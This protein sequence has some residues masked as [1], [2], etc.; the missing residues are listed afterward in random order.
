MVYNPNLE[1]V[2]ERMGPNGLVQIAWNMEFCPP[3]TIRIIT[4]R[5]FLKLGSGL[6][7][8]PKGIY[9]VVTAVERAVSE[10]RIDLDLRV[11]FGIVGELFG[12]QGSSTL[13]KQ[14]K[15]GS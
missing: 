12:Y 7:G 3:D 9:P 5:C 2:V 8:L 15:H 4:E 11:S 1:A 13:T 14:G 6:I 10:T